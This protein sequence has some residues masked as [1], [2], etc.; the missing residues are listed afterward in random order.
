[1]KIRGIKYQSNFTNKFSK[2]QDTKQ[3]E[4]HTEYN[5][6]MSLSSKAYVYN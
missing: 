4:E 2:I 5:P 1:M 3:K 6:T